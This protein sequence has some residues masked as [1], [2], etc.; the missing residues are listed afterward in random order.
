VLPSLSFAAPPL[1]TLSLSLLQLSLN[2][3]GVLL[4]H[5]V[6]PPPWHPPPRRATVGTMMMTTP[7]RGDDNG[8]KARGGGTTR[9]S[10]LLQQ[11]PPSV[12]FPSSDDLLWLN[13]DGSKVQGLDL[14]P[15]GLD[16]GSVFFYFQKLIFSVGPLNQVTL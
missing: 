1:L 13:D 8:S 9:D 10:A 15:M 5:G 12:R 16:L 7:R 2:G 14:G 6:R 4:L 3:H 11:L